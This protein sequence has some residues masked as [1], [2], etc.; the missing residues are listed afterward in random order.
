MALGGGVIKTSQV[1]QW[2][3]GLE[4]V[5]GLGSQAMCPFHKE[6]EKSFKIDMEF[7][8]HC[9]ICEKS[10]HIADLDIT[11]LYR[12]PSFFPEQF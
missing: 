3:K 12:G 1:L 10:G 4:V 7:N 6:R 5:P 8:Y 9:P 2:L 11:E